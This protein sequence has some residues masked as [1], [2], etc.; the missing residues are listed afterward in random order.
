MVANEQ[1]TPVVEQPAPVA[2]EQPTPV[3][4]E[5]SAPVA[6]EQPAPVA[7]IVVDDYEQPIDAH[8]PIEA[9]YGQLELTAPGPS[10]E[11]TRQ[12]PAE[13]VVETVVETAVEAIPVAAAV[14]PAVVADTVTVTFEEPPARAAEDEP[15]IVDVELFYNDTEQAPLVTVEPVS[16]KLKRQLND[17]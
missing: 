14:E 11:A 8:E 6:T 12:P 9:V 3:A 4:T 2:T 13:T 15:A 5:Q 16:A 7:A 10:E 1:S 17:C